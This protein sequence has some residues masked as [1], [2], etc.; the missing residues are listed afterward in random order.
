MGV[1]IDLRPNRFFKPLAS[2]LDQQDTFAFQEGTTTDGTP[3]ILADSLPVPSN[4]AINFKI[5]LVALQSA[6]TGAGSTW[7]HEFLGTIKNIGGTTTLSIITENT[8]QEDAG[9]ALWD[10]AIAANDTTDVLEI[11]VTGEAAKTIN[12]KAHIYYTQVSY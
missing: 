10:G 7:F 8:I 3:L 12:W 9:A 5:R 2:P 1:T 6:G 4:N 11:S